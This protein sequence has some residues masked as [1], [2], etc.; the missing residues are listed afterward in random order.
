MATEEKNDGQILTL[1]NGLRVIF[2][3]TQDVATAYVALLVDC[4]SLYEDARISGISHLLEHLI[5]EEG[6]TKEKRNRLLYRVE[7]TGAE[8]T[9][10]T[11]HQFTEFQLDTPLKKW[12]LNLR[13]FLDMVAGLRCTEEDFAREQKVVLN[14]IEDN[15]GSEATYIFGLEADKRAFGQHSLG[16][17][18][19]GS[20]NTVSSITIEMIKAWHKRFYQP[21]RIVLIVVGNLNLERVIR[22][23]KKSKLYSVAN[24]KT[25]I[26]L[27]P[28]IEPDWDAGGIIKGFDKNIVKIIFPMPSF[29]DEVDGALFYFVQY[30]FDDKSTLSLSWEVERKLGIYGGIEAE[31]N[32]TVCG[33]YYEVTLHAS[34]HKLLKRLERKFF[35]W[36]DAICERGFSNDLFARI[37]NRRKQDINE[38]KSREGYWWRDNH[39]DYIENNRLGSARLFVDIN[40]FDKREMERVFRKYFGGKRLIFR[41]LKRKR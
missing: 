10:C 3:K 39:I 26:R 18:V 25:P 13:L 8:V 4:G 14:E 5:G 21:Q 23:V 31:D 12:A 38:R 30:I 15:G 6:K 40:A 36:I 9:Q 16:F 7:R 34:S 17:D 41:S 27:P 35:A 33:C 2:V 11:G 24:R 28:K 1:E 32:K 29:E 22:V 19:I 20:K 37:R